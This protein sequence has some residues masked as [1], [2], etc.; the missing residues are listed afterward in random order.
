MA[1]RPEGYSCLVTKKSLLAL[2]RILLSAG[3]EIRVL[4]FTKFVA[5]RVI[6]SGTKL[7]VTITGI[8]ITIRKGSPDLEVAL[9]SLNGE[10]SSIKYLLPASFKG[11]IVDGGGYI[12]TAAI[13]LTRL[14]PEAQVI[15][16]EP[17]LSNL[18]ILVANTEKFSKITA[19]HG[20]LVGRPRPSI[21]LHDPGEREWGF[22]TSAD[23]SGLNS[24]SKI[25]V[26]PALTIN[27]LGVDPHLIELL[28]LDIEGGEREILDN[29]IDDVKNIQVVMC[30]LH[31][32]YVD[33]CEQA[34]FS[35]S[36]NRIA[37]KDSG[38]KFISVLPAV[39]QSP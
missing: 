23:H 18:E 31:E 8:P 2:A 9:T 22:T 5:L 37:F 12:G 19:L 10:F 7:E 13:A 25:D 11:V 27:D 34:F 39:K 36:E 17:S 38:E 15:S 20:A 3:R 32:H 24:S 21:E 1:R 35:F 6:P 14:F 4:G 33:G 16:I 30:E 29:P 28:K 26:V